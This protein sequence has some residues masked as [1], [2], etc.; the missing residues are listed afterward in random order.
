MMRKAFHACSS[1]S[2]P[3]T[4]EDL[5]QGHRENYKIY[6]AAST[7]LVAYEELDH[8]KF[9]LG[10]TTATT[11]PSS[12]ATP[13]SAG[14]KSSTRRQLNGA[15]YSPVYG[16]N[17]ANFYP[18]VLDGDWMRESEPMKRRG[19]AQRPVHLRGRQL[20]VLLQER[21]RVRLRPLDRHLIAAVFGRH[22]DGAIDGSVSD[23]AAA[24]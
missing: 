13:C 19:T 2:R 4:V 7:S 15:T 14:S 21:P 1:S 10:S 18:V 24:D 12:T 23:P 11:S 20:P 16:V 22:D 8:S 17:H 9:S 5:E 3:I 6:M